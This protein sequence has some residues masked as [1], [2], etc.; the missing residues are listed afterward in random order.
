MHLYWLLRYF[1]IVLYRRPDDG[2]KGPKHVAIYK[3]RWLCST[4]SKQFAFEYWTKRNGMYSIKLN[5]YGDD[6]T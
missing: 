5:L 2:R 1:K 3:E 4:D 6:V